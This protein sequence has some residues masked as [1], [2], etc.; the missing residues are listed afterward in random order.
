MR[1]KEQAS[2]VVKVRLFGRD[3]NIRG[4]GAKRHVEELAEFIRQRVETIQQKAKVVTTID[5]VVLTL[6]DITDEMF[7]YKQVK[8]QTIKELEEKTERLLKSID[9]TI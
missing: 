4:H 1:H 7:Q 2:D 6:L 9:R 8:E 5:L 3:Y